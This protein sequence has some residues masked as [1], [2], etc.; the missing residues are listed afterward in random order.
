M[1]SRFANQVTSP[2]TIMAPSSSPISIRFPHTATKTRL[3]HRHIAASGRYR[4]QATKPLLSLV[5]LRV[6]LHGSRGGREGVVHRHRHV[7]CRQD[8]R[9][10]T[11][12]P[13]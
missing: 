8:P 10:M 11:D 4:T 13:P 12:D 3:Q 7:V 5:D 6:G 1:H 2:T 9:E